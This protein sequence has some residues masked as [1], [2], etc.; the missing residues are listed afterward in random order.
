M[1]K[2]NTNNSEVTEVKETK[3]FIK[4]MDDLYFLR[5]LSIAIIIFVGSIFLYRA[6]DFPEYEI[7]PTHQETET[8]P[9]DSVSDA[10][11]ELMISDRSIKKE[12]EYISTMYSDITVHIGDE[13]FLVNDPANDQDVYVIYGIYDSEQQPI[14]QTG[15]FGAGEQTAF[16]PSDY[17]ATGSHDIEIVQTSYRKY[18]NKLIRINQCVDSVKLTIS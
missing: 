7:A 15:W 3:H 9:V 14:Y 17:F 13:I 5:N 18:G 4:D 1:E 6:I 2:N 16:V 11:G 8:I 12:N 10:N